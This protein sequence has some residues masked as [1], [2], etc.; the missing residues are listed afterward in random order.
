LNFARDLKGYDLKAAERV[1]DKVSSHQGTLD[2]QHVSQ[3][4]RERWQSE[5]WLLVSVLAIAGLLLIFGLIADEV[6]EGSTLAFDRYVILAY[7]SAG[8]SSDP[9]GP[10]WVQGMAR[11]IT[12]LGSFAV[13]AIVLFAVVGYLLLSHRLAAALL[14][15]AAVLGGVAMNSLLKLGIARPRPDFVASSVKVFT[16]SFPSGHAAI[17]AITYLTLAALLARTTPS[18]RL[19]LYFVTIGIMLTLLVGVSRVYLGVHYPTDV[20]A[21]WCV[22]S[23]WALG[24]WAV[25]TRLQRAGQVEPP[26]EH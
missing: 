7:R 14:V 17:S 11:D 9:I 2:M 20:L 3:W 5:T 13:L 19:G 16:A 4:V 8:N 18:R 21:G 23:A 24:C 1:Y 10:P 15:L 26:E 12:A 22:G 25:M 6:M